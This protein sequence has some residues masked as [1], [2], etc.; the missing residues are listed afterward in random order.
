MNLLLIT[1]SL[2]TWHP[3]Q[4]SSRVPRG[5]DDSSGGWNFSRG[6]RLPKHHDINH[7]EG[8]W[9]SES[10]GKSSCCRLEPVRNHLHQMHLKCESADISSSL[11][12]YHVSSFCYDF[13][14]HKQLLESSC[15]DFERVVGSNWLNWWPSRTVPEGMQSDINQSCLRASWLPTM[16]SNWCYYPICSPQYIY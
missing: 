16:I 12:S 4:Q 13:Y 15:S 11:S 6:S 2:K 10:T 7:M 3:R 14:Y 5:L 8:W 9:L 1:T